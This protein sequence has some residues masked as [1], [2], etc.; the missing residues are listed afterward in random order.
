MVKKIM[1]IVL[2]VLTVVTFLLTIVIL[3]FGTITIKQ[4]KMIKIFGYSYSAVATDSMKGTIEVGDMILIKYDD[5][6][7]IKENDIIVF[8]SDINNDGVD[9]QVSHRV[10]EISEDGT[11]FTTKGDN[12]RAN[13]DEKKVTKENY[14]GKVVK[15]GNVGIGNVILNYKNYV[16]GAIALIFVY[17]IISQIIS[18]VKTKSEKEKEKLKEENEKE[19]E[20]ERAKIKEELLSELEKEENE[21]DN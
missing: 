20:L 17:I 18:I 1:N 12:P 11:E 8:Y 10:I 14:I 4:G 5:F 6:E 7:E 9:E 15:Y 2:T 21:S 19:L 13:V 3:I 16:F